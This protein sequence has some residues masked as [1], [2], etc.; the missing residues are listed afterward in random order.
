MGSRGCQRA[1]WTP[2][3]VRAGAP[4]TECGLGDTSPLRRMRRCRRGSRY[5][6]SGDRGPVTSGRKLKFG[7]AVVAVAVVIAAV[8]VAVVASNPGEVLTG[9]CIDAV[10]DTYEF[11]DNGMFEPGGQLRAPDDYV[12]WTVPA[13]APDGADLASVELTRDGDG[14]S[15]T[16]TLAHRWIPYPNFT[17]PGDTGTFEGLLTG[18]DVTVAL[19]SGEWVGTVKIADSAAPTAFRVSRA[20]TPGDHREAV[21]NDP[22][23]DEN[24][25]TVHIP[26]SELDQ[27]GDTFEFS[28][29]SSLITDDVAVL[30]NCPDLE[31]LSAEKPAVQFPN[32]SSSAG[33]VR[34]RGTPAPAPAPSTPPSTL[35]RTDPAAAAAGPPECPHEWTEPLHDLDLIAKCLYTAYRDGD[36]D[37]AAI[38][39]DPDAVAKLF[40]SP[41]EPPEWQF[42][43]CEENASVPPYGY[44]YFGIHG[45][46]HGV[47][48]EMMLDG[49]LSAGL[50]VAAV[51]YYG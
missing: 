31:T 49:G 10:G 18:T 20:D 41:W 9:A 43:R 32:D 51:E 21:I 8:S 16:V 30:D 46:P 11:H 27:F 14:L 1:R 15:V 26:G 39:G 12:S 24:R 45:E 40:E 42:D 4:S 34:S 23:F 13:T 2:E 28:A 19:H 38:F 44:C 33:H 7:A 6:A 3:R 48:I 5:R 25:A 17:E 22:V 29:S 50:T 36:R 47:Q 37:R 35:P